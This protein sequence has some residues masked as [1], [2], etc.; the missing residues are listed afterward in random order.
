MSHNNDHN[1]LIL[2]LFLLFPEVFIILGLGYI[3]FYILAGIAYLI[4][5]LFVPLL[6]IGIIIFIVYAL[7]NKKKSQKIQT[8]KQKDALKQPS[9]PENIKSTDYDTDLSPDN[10]NGP[11]ENEE[12]QRIMEE[13]DLD[14]DDA[15]RVQEIAEE[16]GIDEDEAAE[17]INDL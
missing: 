6:V 12:K 15:E 17:L 7:N 8:N 14:E 5:I 3:L 11:E 13:Y 1:L 10:F 4:Y 2:I 16:W 9:L